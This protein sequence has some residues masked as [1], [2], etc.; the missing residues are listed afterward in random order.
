MMHAYSNC[1]QAVSLK[2]RDVRSTNTVSLNAV[3][4]NHGDH[5][6]PLLVADQL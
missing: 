4:I 6:L 3:D 2:L 1:V 5:V